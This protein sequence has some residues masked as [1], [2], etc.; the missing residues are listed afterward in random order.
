MPVLDGLQA[1]QSTARAKPA[2]DNLPIVAFT[3]HAMQAD[4]EVRAA[5]PLACSGL[6]SPN[7]LSR[8]RAGGARCCAGY[9]HATRCRRSMLPSSAIATVAVHGSDYPRRLRPG[10]SL[11]RRPCRRARQQ[12]PHGQLARCTTTSRKPAPMPVDVVVGIDTARALEHF[13]NSSCAVD[14]AHLEC[15]CQSQYG[16]VLQIS[17]LDRRLVGHANSASELHRAAHTL[18]RPGRHRGRHRLA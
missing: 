18:A 16:A 3:A 13:D 1:T 2:F 10:Q 7:R 17:T 12:A 14:A 5:W 15:F 8:D 9:R 4:R 11:R 6:S